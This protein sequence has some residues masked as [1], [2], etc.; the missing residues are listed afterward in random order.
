MPNKPIHTI[1]REFKLSSFSVDNK[2]SMFVVMGILII[3]GVMA[4]R[5]MPKETFPEIVIP[6]V[7]VGTSYPGN[8]PVDIEN[9]ITRPI[10][11]QLKGMSGVK[12]INSSSVQDYS[13]I[14]VDFNADVEVSKALLDVKDAVDR[15]KND[16]PTD[17]DRDPNISE[18]NFSE[19]PIMNINLSG[20]FSPDELKRYAE[21]AQDEIEAL[22]EISKVDIKGAQD[23]EVRVT[24][25]LQRLTATQVSFTD[26]EKA[27]AQE[28][29]TISGGDILTDEFRRNLRVVGEFKSPEELEEIIVKHEKGNIVF[30]RDI[31]EIEFDFEPRK[32]YARSE[33]LPVVSLDV[34]KRSGENLIIASDQI[35]E[36]IDHAKVHKFPPNLDVSIVNDQSRMTRLQLNDLENSIVFGVILVVLVLLFFLGMRNS[37]FVAIAIPLSMLTAFLLLSANGVTL[38][39]MILFS[40]ILALGMLVDNGIVVVENIYRLRQE[41]YPPVQAAKEGVGEVAWPIITST[42]TTLAAFVP[43]IFWDDIMGEFMKYL[44]ITLIIVLASSLFVALVI[45]PVLTAVFMKVQELRKKAKKRRTLVMAMALAIIGLLLGLLGGFKL[46]QNLF[47]FAGML[48]LLNVFLLEPGSIRFQNIILPKLEHAYH[49]LISFALRGWNPGFFLIGMVFLLIFSFIFLGARAPK[50]HLFPENEPQYVNV[51]IEMP[52]GTD[53]EKTNEVTWKLEGLVIDTLRNNWGVVEAVLANVGEGTADAMSNPMDGV[54]QS[55]TPHRAKISVFFVAFED[56]DGVQTSRLMENI[57][58]C[59][60]TIPGAKITVGKDAVGPPVGKPISLEVSGE[61]YEKLIQVTEDIQHY[62]ESFNIPGIEALKTDLETGKPELI[63]KIDRKAARRFGVS[64][65]QIASSLR[66]ALFGKEVSKFKQNEDEYP[67]HV[68]LTDKNR[69]N[70]SDLMNLHITFKDQSDGKTVH[71]P[72]SA[73]AEVKYSSSFGSVRRKDLNKVVMLTSNVREGYN[74]TEIVDRIKLEME[75]FDLPAGYE[76]RFTGEQE[77]QAKQMRFLS[78]ALMIAVFVIFLIIVAQFNSLA[79]PIIIMFSV[80]F[81]VI[82]VFLGI[83]IFRMDFIVIMTGIGIISL[84]GVVVNNA[85]VLIDYTDLVR[86][87]KRKELGLVDSLLPDDEMIKCIIEGGKT[88][89]RPVLLTAITTVL[90]LIPLAYGINIDFFELARNLEP[91]YF[92]GGDNV[93]FW[94]PMAKTVIF[95]LTFSTFLTLVIVPVMYLVVERMKG[96][97]RNRVLPVLGGE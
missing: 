76:L 18:M 48:V 13:S 47:I 35:K 21:Y 74:A 85:I 31:A 83:A 86:E 33:K 68:R 53:I 5:D 79:T 42:A 38:N 61:D 90:G 77:E 51:F 58:N 64:T 50:I 62:I 10:E 11:K 80:I 84:A 67:I 96:F 22:P 17:L 8:S 59:V 23:R 57:R 94:G 87:R 19:M 56:R 15:A 37:L 36:I 1:I 44:P 60:Q 46:A 75:D 66:T 28:N 3:L 93:V 95:G 78:R 43:L 30:L 72:V 20:D 24:V 52:L 49:R 41:G 71:L 12:E 54:Q 40:M 25:D 14:I 88:R 63:M 73:V 70:L 81:S 6:T 65:S 7:F 89:L 16:L 45:N 9:L 97:M 39:I 69:Y 32:S 27:I 34:K 29:R 4:Y 2:T 92:I 91:H 26:I 55:V 82:G